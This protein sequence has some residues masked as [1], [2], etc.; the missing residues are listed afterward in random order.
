MEDAASW[1][2]LL[3]ALA[4]LALLRRRPR[5]APRHGP[6][7]GPPP[8]L[9]PRELLSEFRDV[10]PRHA[11][12]AADAAAAFDRAFQRTFDAGARDSP[13]DRVRQLFAHRARAQLN[14]NELRLRLPNDLARERRLAALAER[15]D[16]G[17]LEHVEDA[18]Q[19]CSAPLLH[20][21]PVDDAWYGR[22]YRAANDV[23]A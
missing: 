23:V 16:R 9:L 5:A 4:L 12:A 19:R 22:W 14:L 15:L 2:A 7:G 3:A 18:R 17:M 6:G 8:R 10:S 1:V 13:A 21:G 20:P 11:A